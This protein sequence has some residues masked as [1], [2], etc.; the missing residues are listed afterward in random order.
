MLVVVSCA[1]VGSTRAQYCNPAVVSY[2]VHDQDGDL[3]GATE[4]RA[5][6]AQLPT[7]IGDAHPDTGEVS[8]RDD[9]TTFY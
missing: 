8:F 1:C 6:Q 4:L 3:L 9:G 5:I 7:S 2:I